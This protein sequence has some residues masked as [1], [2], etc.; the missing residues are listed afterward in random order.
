MIK[1]IKDLR[2]KLQLPASLKEFQIS[3]DEFTN[4]LDTISKESV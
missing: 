3:Q 2:R 1:H 4:N